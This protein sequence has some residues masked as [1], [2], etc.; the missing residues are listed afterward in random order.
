MARTIRT[1]VFPVAGLG[2]RMLPATKS[3][4]KEMLPVLDKP[5][6]QYGVEEARAAGIERLVFVT[7]GGKTAIEDHFDRSAA[8]EDTLLRKGKTE[9]LAKSIDFVPPPGEIVHVRQQ[10]PLGLG[11]AVWSARTIVGDE[12]FAVILVDDLILGGQGCLSE[13]I[14]AHGRT[15]GNVIATMEVPEEHTSRYGIIDPGTLDDALVEVRG[16]VEK[17]DAR[18]APSRFAVIGRYILMPEVF[19]HLDKQQTGAGGEIQLTDAMIPLI[20][21]QPFHGLKFSGRRFDCGSPDGYIR[22]IIAAAKSHPELR[23]TLI[24]ALREEVGL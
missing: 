5:I 19:E 18:A 4:P 16:L 17:P 14:A 20:A 12:P 24:P 1:A 23:E 2:T 7:S 9:I 3:I 22:A 21:N 6:I 11:H 15:N 8:L 13:M 10:Q